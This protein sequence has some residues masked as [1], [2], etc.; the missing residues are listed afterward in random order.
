MIKK[1]FDIDLEKDKLNDLEQVSLNDILDE[2]F[3]SN[4]RIKS[5]PIK[6]TVW[7]DT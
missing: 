3:K 4:S 6:P 7:L 5:I 1:E 2:I